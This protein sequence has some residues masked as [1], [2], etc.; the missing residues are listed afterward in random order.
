MASVRE[1]AEHLSVSPATVSRVLNSRPGI[2][3][4]TRKRVLEAASQMGLGRHTGLKTT[5]Y[6]GYVHPLGHFVGHMG[7]YHASLIGG[8]VACLGQDQ[9]DLALIDP[10]RDKRP[11]ETYAQFFMRKDL[12]GVIVQVR[13]E[14]AHV[15]EKIAEERFPMVTVASTCDS[16]KVN[17]VVCDSGRETQRAVEYLGG[18]GHRRIALAIRLELDHDHLARREGY[19]AAMRG[20]FGEADPA[21]EFGVFSE[22]SAGASLIRRF[23]SLAQPPTAVVFT[24]SDPTLGALAACREMGLDVPGRLSVIGFDDSAKRY[25]C[26][27]PFTAI[28]QDAQRLGHEAAS[29]LVK[30]MEGD[31]TPPIRV[32]LPAAFEVHATTGPPPAH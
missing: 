8:I 23:F 10:Y 20:M 17:W 31:L 29:S 28:C 30:L 3:D 32:T 13:A 1:I 21:L 9:Y 15:V 2:G 27:P 14:N 5:R 26:V 12:R 22:M 16:P 19:R 25:Q 24:N 4:A 11:D 18:L 6:V 7:D